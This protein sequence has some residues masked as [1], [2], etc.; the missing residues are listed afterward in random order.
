MAASMMTGPRFMAANSRSKTTEADP[1]GRLRNEVE[2]GGTVSTPST[3]SA[4]GDPLDEFEAC[5]R[6][7][8]PMLPIG[9]TVYGDLCHHY[10]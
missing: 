5:F 2:T 3:N 10:L 7:Y 1:L 6:K 8:G 9:P 4:E